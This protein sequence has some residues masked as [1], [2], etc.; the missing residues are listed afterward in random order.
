MALYYA[1]PY[2]KGFPLD[3]AAFVCAAAIGDVFPFWTLSQLYFLQNGPY[4]LVIQLFS[5]QTG[6]VPADCSY[7]C[8]S[9]Y[10]LDICPRLDFMAVT[11]PFLAWS[12]LK[13]ISIVVFSTLTV[14]RNEVVLLQALNL[15]GSLSLK[16]LKTH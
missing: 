7:S 9:S 6:W 11:T 1:I 4:V 2:S 12:S 3:P 15:A 5:S 14:L 10:L 16:I 13:G 8:N